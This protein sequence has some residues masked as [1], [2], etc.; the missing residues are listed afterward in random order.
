MDPECECG[1][2]L[3]DPKG[4]IVTVS[5]AACKGSRIWKIY[6]PEGH[7]VQLTFQ[8]FN[9]RQSASSA[10]LEI[11]DGDSLRDRLLFSEYSG[12]SLPAPILTTQHKMHIEFTSPQLGGAGGEY[13][14][15]DEG[16]AASYISFGEFGIPM[17]FSVKMEKL[18]GGPYRKCIFRMV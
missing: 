15:P 6:A 8:Y 12:S 13:N 3:D 7:V 11:R 14:T 4:N 9:M 16:F 5:T 2:V 1:C 17:T 18:G 10:P